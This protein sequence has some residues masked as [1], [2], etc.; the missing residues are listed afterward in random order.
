M[1]NSNYKKIVFYG[2]IPEKI[3][4]NYLINAD[5]ALLIL[6]SNPVFDMTIPAKLQTYLSCGCPVLGCVQGICK[7]LIDENKLGLTTDIISVPE[8]VKVCKLLMNNRNVLKEYSQIK[9]Y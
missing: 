2:Q 5:A 6:K 1:K 7:K 3:I 8:F 4:P 9:Y